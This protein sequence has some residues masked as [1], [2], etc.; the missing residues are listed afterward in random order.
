M[1]T[2]KWGDGSNLP[3]H[4]ENQQHAPKKIQIGDWQRIDCK[5]DEEHDDNYLIWGA[6]ILSW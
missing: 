1:A 6:L 2:Q 4:G 3:K 5:F